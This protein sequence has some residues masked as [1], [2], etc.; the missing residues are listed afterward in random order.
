MQLNVREFDKPTSAVC[1]HP[2]DEISLDLADFE[3]LMRLSLP[4]LQAVI[5]ILMCRCRPPR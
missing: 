2:A 1:S 5:G 3:D 4:D